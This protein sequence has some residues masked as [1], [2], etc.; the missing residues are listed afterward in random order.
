MDLFEHT[1]TCIYIYIYIHTHIYQMIP[2]RLI[3]FKL[4]E[5]KDM[6]KPPREILPSFQ[7]L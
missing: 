3:S 6:K 1:H 2:L 7:N 4:L 5:T